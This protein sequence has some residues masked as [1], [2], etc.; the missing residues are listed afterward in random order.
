MFAQCVGLEQKNKEYGF[1]VIC[2]G[3]GMVDTYMQQVAR[4]KTIDEYAMA[5]FFKQ[6]F[7]DGKLQK[8]DIVAEKIYTILTNINEQGT[9]VKVDGG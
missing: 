2:I 7:E 4:S 1:E 8:P 3:P 5:D 6:A 9:Y